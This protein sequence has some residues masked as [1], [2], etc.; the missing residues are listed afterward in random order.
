[1]A[2][3]ML[4]R[5]VLKDFGELP[6]KVQKKVF[7]LVRKVQEDSTQAS[8]HLEPYREAVDPKVRSA[9]VGDDY[10]LSGI[11]CGHKV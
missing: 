1:M 4:F 2:R 3:L 10:R 9:R 11:S 7:E 5:D 6:G 8:I